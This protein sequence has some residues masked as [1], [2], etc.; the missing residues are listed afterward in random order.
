MVMAFSVCAQ[1]PTPKPNVVLILV[2]TL[3]ADHLGC[4]GY[5]HNVSPNIDRLAAQ[6]KVFT[7]CYSVA[8]W[9]LPSMV[10]IITSLYPEVHGVKT[11]KDRLGD[12]G[13]VLAEVL[14]GHGYSTG[15][16]VTSSFLTGTWN[17]DRGFDFFSK[18]PASGHSGVTSAAATYHGRKFL[19]EQA[20]T[21][22]FLM[23]HYFDPHTEYIEH[24]KFDFTSALGYKGPLEQGMPIIDVWPL[25]NKKLMTDDDTAFLKA[26]YDSEIA[27]TD[28]C[29]GGLLETLKEM[30]VFENT[31]IIL[32]SDHGEEFMD[33]GGLEHSRTL[34]EELIHVPLIIKMP[35]S[36]QP[37]SLSIV[38]SVL[39]VFPTAL[40]ALSLPA[41]P[42]VFGIS[43]AKSDS[44]Q[45]DRVLF[46]SS[47]RDGDK[48]SAL[49]GHLKLIHNIK[50]GKREYYDLQKD[51]KESQPL[52]EPD[53][54]EFQNLD[55]ALEKWQE[56]NAA[57]Q[58]LSASTEL[59]N[60][61]S[62]ELKSL[63]YL[64]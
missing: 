63:G 41:Q 6:S 12:K 25:I 38:V 39:D 33:H 11:E 56:I 26:L 62:E 1:E 60:E 24:G 22:F 59:T 55:H 35:N 14:R 50:S 27:F 5:Q 17:F 64:R 2:D 42:G 44:M 51:P 29:I 40:D 32:T 20:K 21:P 10:S 3:R 54:P 37:E 49:S 52:D 45:T 7:R 9:T 48:M 61:L 34:Y 58:P 19:K 53:R 4:Y 47:Y 28:A 46:A 23:M 31:L 30:G 36:S 16:V 8:P 57:Q 13:T 15:A 43:L 18:K